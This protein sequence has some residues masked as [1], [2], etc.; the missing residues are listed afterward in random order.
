MARC[1][2]ILGQVR[3]ALITEVKEFSKDIAHFMV[4]NMI[5]G[6]REDLSHSH[7]C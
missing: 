6:Q 5:L 2:T 4:P 1:I 3:E 7:L